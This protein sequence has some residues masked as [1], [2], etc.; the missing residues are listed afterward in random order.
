MMSDDLVHAQLSKKTWSCLIFKKIASRELPEPEGVGT[1]LRLSYLRNQPT[2]GVAPIDCRI[3][4]RSSCR[5][6]SCPQVGAPA[7]PAALVPGIDCG[8]D[9][10]GQ[11]CSASSTEHYCVAS[12]S[13]THSAPL[14]STPLTTPQRASRGPRVPTCSAA[15]GLPALI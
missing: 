7:R 15:I 8:A 2:G 4:S 9:P 14:H 1:A 3:W 10:V 13:W 6:W 5:N 11:T 12:E